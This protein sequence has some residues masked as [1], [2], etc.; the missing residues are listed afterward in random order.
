MVTSF[1]RKPEQ[2]SALLAQHSLP[3]HLTAGPQTL[4]QRLQPSL[5]PLL[6]LRYFPRTSLRGSTAVSG[7]LK[8]VRPGFPGQAGIPMNSVMEEESEPEKV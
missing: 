1:Q 5:S 6:L 4:P 8:R 2:L 3:P 7:Q